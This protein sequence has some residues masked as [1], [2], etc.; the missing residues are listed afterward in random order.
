[1][2]GASSAGVAH[3]GRV[4]RR[5]VVVGRRVRVVERPHPR[6]AVVLVHHDDHEMNMTTPTLS[7]SRLLESK[8]T[9]PQL[10]LTKLA[11]AH[12]AT[13]CA[14]HKNVKNTTK[15]DLPAAQRGHSRTRCTYL[16]KPQI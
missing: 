4:G 3:H 11:S 12:F 8:D 5:L 7:I 9:A 1:M 10:H 14:M 6:P 13:L 2:R 15:L 16:I